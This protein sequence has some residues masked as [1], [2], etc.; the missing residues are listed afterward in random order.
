MMNPREGMDVCKWRVPLRHGGTVNSS[1]TESPFVKL[2]EGEE[3]GKP[4]TIPKAFSLKIG[5]EPSQIVLSPAW[6]SKLRLTTGVQS[7]PL[8]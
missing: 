1:R 7:S 5:V 4:L 2:M 6:C 3:R 8:F